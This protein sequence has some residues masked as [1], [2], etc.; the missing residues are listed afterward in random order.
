MLKYQQAPMLSMKGM[1]SPN[2]WPSP[3]QP[4]LTNRTSFLARLI[5]PGIPIGPLPVYFADFLQ[6]LREK[7]KDLN[8][9]GQFV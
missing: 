9:P 2:P 5:N 1:T 4:E 6:Y 7:I 8:N 3:G